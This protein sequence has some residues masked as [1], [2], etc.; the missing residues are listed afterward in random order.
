[1]NAQLRQPTTIGPQVELDP[2][3]NALM[4]ARALGLPPKFCDW[5]ELNWA[6]WFEFVKLADKMRIRGR[7]HYSARAVL[8]VL[9]WERALR[10]TT[11]DDFKINNDKSAKLARLYN[12]MNRVDFFL[13]REPGEA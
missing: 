4:H 5:L 12:A 9:R 2:Q 10:D 7:E 11:Q 3:R 1:M 6:I 8:H 13:T